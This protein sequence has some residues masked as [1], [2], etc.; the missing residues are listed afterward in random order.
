MQIASSSWVLR[1]QELPRRG[2]VAPVSA[3]VFWTG[4]VAEQNRA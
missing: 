3:G 1:G 2:N 4:W